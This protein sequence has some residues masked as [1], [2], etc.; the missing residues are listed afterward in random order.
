MSFRDGWPLT[1]IVNVWN[2]TYK[3]KVGG[4]ESFKRMP[5]ESMNQSFHSIYFLALE[6]I[7]YFSRLWIKY[8]I[9]RVCVTVSFL[10]SE[11]CLA[12]SEFRYIRLL[13]ETLP[14]KI[15]IFLWTLYDF[16]FNFNSE[17]DNKM[18][19]VA[20]HNGCVHNKL[21][22]QITLLFLI[23]CDGKTKMFSVL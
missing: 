8:K 3:R 10:I 16:I 9:Q 21:Q 23:K 20:T 15:H 7:F 12:K 17:K 4:N 5:F 19:C 1:I 14:L 11:N 2:V 22:D 6:L 18:C 13:I